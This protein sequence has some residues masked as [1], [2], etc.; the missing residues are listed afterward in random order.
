L[1]FIWIRWNGSMRVEEIAFNSH[2]RFISLKRYFSI[3]FGVTFNSH[4]RFIGHEQCFR[5][6][7]SNFHFQFSFEIHPLFNDNLQDIVKI[8][9]QFSFEIHPTSKREG[10]SKVR[11]LL[12]ILIW[13]SS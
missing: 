7:L 8:S 9:F 10:Y 13:D 2:L 4:L 12:S 6:F 1:R 3:V 5:L 11:S